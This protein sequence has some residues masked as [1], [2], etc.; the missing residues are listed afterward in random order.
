MGG[1]AP[2]AARPSGEREGVSPTVPAPAMGAPRTAREIV[3]AP[4]STPTPGKPAAAAAP[5]DRPAQAGEAGGSNELRQRAAADKLPADDA[6]LGGKG[7][8]FGKPLAEKRRAAKDWDRTGGKADD[9]RLHR[10]DK[11]Q[12]REEADA[13]LDAL[14][15]DKPS[16]RKPEPAA[17]QSSK[18]LKD[19]GKRND[20][21]EQLADRK[22][23]AAAFRPAAKA[24]E[25]SRELA[26]PNGHAAG[27]VPPGFD[28]HATDSETLVWQPRVVTQADGRADIRFTLPE[29][30]LGYRVLIDAHADGRIGSQRCEFR[31]P[32]R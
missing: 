31:V 14:A 2:G 3:R 10:R 20:A 23:A 15:A 18:K 19:A 16:G 17:G 13:K 26:A 7:A 25:L 32:A 9:D 30:I 27:L 5:A 4:A 29:N 6:V 12:V 8:A 11:S 24:E 28:F 21:M 22:P 1:P